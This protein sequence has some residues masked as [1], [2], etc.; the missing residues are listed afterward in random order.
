VNT[1]TATKIW[2]SVFDEANDDLEILLNNL[3]TGD[4][5]IIQ[6]KSDATQ[7]QNWDITS[8][9]LTSGVQVEY[10]V[11]LASGTFNFGTLADDHPILVIANN[12]GPIGPAGPA[13]P[14]GPT[15]AVGATGATGAQGATGAT[16]AQGATGATG[17]IGPT[18]ATG[19]TGPHGDT[20]ATG[21]Q[22]I[23]GVMGATGPQGVQGLQGIQGIQGATGATGAT[24]STGATGATNPNATGIT[25]TDTNTNATYYPTFVAG[26]GASQ[27]LLAD[28]SPTIS[29]SYNPSTNTLTTAAGTNSGSL[30]PSVLQF[31]SATST[32]GL[33]SGGLQLNALAGNGTLDY[34]SF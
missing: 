7:F 34:Q 19:A 28:V 5:F 17:A 23:Q 29:L 15:G 6:D 22:G 3:T 8:S 16:G 32:S 2:I 33:S 31:S 9:T 26:A 1:I 14:A 13:G 20:G 27:S 10:D 24:G 18:G 12:V 30:S 11:V 25:I 21:P 4:S